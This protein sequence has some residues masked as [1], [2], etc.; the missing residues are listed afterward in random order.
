[1]D[2]FLNIFKLFYLKNMTLPRIRID[3]IR[4]PSQ[5]FCIRR[6]ESESQVFQPCYT[7]PHF[8]TKILPKSC[9]HNIRYISRTWNDSPKT[10]LPIS[11]THPHI[12]SSY[13]DTIIFLYNS[14]FSSPYL[15][16]HLASS[17]HFFNSKFLNPKTP[18]PF[19]F[20]ISLH[21]GKCIF[22]FH[23]FLPIG[24]SLGSWIF[25]ERAISFI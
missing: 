12:S 20:I 19:G 25:F 5:V 17:D 1:M 16:H 8:E 6:V 11:G 9:P 7:L 23:N 22:L 24:S 14:S 15:Y 21:L 13:S 18:T 2:S 10:R 4:H 3:S